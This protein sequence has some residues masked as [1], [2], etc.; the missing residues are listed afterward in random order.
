MTTKTISSTE[1]RKTFYGLMR[2]VVDDAVPIV[3]RN[4]GREN[5][6]MM[7]ESEF[8][9]LQETLYLLS[10]HNGEHLRESEEQL[11]RGETTPVTLEEIERMLAE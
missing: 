10:G 11:R 2:E 9:A 8:N 7:P 6:V 4:R 1:A 3:V 5:V